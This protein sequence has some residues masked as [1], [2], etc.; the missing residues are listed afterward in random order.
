[1]PAPAGCIFARRFLFRTR[2][3]CAANIALYRRTLAENGH[4]PS[5]RDVAGVFPMYCGESKA[6]SLRYGGE[7]TLNY[8]KFFG[9][10]ERGTAATTARG[11]GDHGIEFYDDLGLVLIGEPDY[12]IERI[13]WA[14]RILRHQLPAV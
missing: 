1:M 13:R 9:S 10:L 14:R 5:Q 8:F 6:Q 4:D 3:R 7:C 11:F 12:L 2:K